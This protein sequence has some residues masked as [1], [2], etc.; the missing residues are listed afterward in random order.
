M[1]LVGIPQERDGKK[2]KVPV[3]DDSEESDD[4]SEESVEKDKTKPARGMKEKGKPSIEV[5]LNMAVLI[6]VTCNP[7]R[8][9]YYYIRVP[10]NKGKVVMVM[11]CACSPMSCAC[12]HLWNHNGVVNAVLWNHNA[13]ECNAMQPQFTF[14]FELFTWHLCRS[15]WKSCR[16]KIAMWSWWA[17]EL[18]GRYL[19]WL[20]DDWCCEHNRMQC[21]PI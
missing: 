15:S 21:G 4:S 18:V 6:F 1:Q 3:E 12:V 2:K 13:V 10:R 7:Q 14:R 20:M 5:D 19:Q 11:Q 8:R 9:K 16:E 17:V